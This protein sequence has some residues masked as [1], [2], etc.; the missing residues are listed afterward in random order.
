MVP[1][2]PVLRTLQDA[3][4]TPS[5]TLFVGYEAGREW[6]LPDIREAE[7]MIVV[8]PITTVFIYDIIMYM[9]VCMYIYIYIIY[10]YVIYTC[11]PS[12]MTR[13]QRRIRSLQ[14]SERDNR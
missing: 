5:A 9:I 12:T 4:L 13:M 6:F 8:A 2:V 11:P 1:M 3:G 10:I 7:T 14:K